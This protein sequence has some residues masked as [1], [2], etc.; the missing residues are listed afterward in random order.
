MFLNKRIQL[1]KAL[2]QFLVL[3][4]KIFAWFLNLGQLDFMLKIIC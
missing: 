2:L 3:I 1:I 4:R